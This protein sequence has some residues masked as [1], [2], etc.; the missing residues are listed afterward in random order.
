MRKNSLLILRFK[1]K[2]S[3]CSAA[4]ILW[5]VTDSD[6]QLILSLSSVDLSKSTHW[7]LE[8]KITCLGF[9]FKLQISLDFI[10]N[11]SKAA[12]M[13]ATHKKTLLI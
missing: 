9:F 5:A 4:V 6:Q 11:T 13:R 7:F 2:L 3:P 12:I 8:I 10:F 1:T